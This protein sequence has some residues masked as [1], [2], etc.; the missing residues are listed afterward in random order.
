MKGVITLIAET[1]TVNALRIEETTET[2]SDVYADIDSI[3]QSEYFA[4]QDADLNPEYRFR[5]FF[6]DYHGE[7]LVEFEGERFSVYRT[8]RSS[9]RVELYTERKAG[10]YGGE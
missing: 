8:F 10:T 4:A 5:V 7:K 1:V 6:A 2:R 3:S 9:D